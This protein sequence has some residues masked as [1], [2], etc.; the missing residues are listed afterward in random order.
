MNSF[1]YI[2]IGGGIAG[3]SVARALS[4][5]GKT[6]VL[7]QESAPGY[8]S[9]SRS[10][11]LFHF[12]IG[13]P[14]VRAMTA[15]SGPFFTAPPDGFAEVPL[16]KPS[17]ILLVVRKGQ[18]D[19]LEH[20]YT[21]IRAVTDTTRRV[22]LDQIAA[23]VPVLRV[24][25]EGVTAGI[26]DA[27]GLRL[28]GDA[29]LQGHVRALRRNGGQ[30]LT[31]AM[32]TKLA[33][34]GHGWNVATSGGAFSAK[35]V[36]NAAGAWADQIATLA[37]VTPLGLEPLRRTIIAFDPPVGVNC[38]VWPFVRSLADEFYFLPE[39][40]KLLASS[41]DEVPSLPCDAQPDD[42]DIALAAHRIEE[43][44]TMRVTRISHKWAGLRTFA[45]DRVP[46][47][48]FDAQAPGF[49]WLAGQG[50]YGL[51]TSPAMAD[52]AAALI[53]GQPWPQ[54]LSL[55]GVTDRTLSPGRFAAI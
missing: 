2:V 33:R 19:I 55:L 21:Q 14:P 10:A 41:A 8:H 34:D 32:I 25:V 46:V 54:R 26:F 11:T 51:Q 38:A 17:G 40:G 4:R 27:H 13:N 29:L 36:V 44:T 43:V 1:D 39:A 37:G 16:A 12:G 18:E 9:S 31:N 52:A 7:E 28:D 24:G 48:G 22:T 3:L 23:M 50:G 49:F 45:P 53:T 5:H 47:C 6:L 35:V 20:H 15:Y 42:Y 30:I